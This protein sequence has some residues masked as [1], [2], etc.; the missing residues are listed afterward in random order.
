MGLRR[1]R[2]RDEAGNA[3]PDTEDLEKCVKWMQ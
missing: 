1:W 2:S 3:E